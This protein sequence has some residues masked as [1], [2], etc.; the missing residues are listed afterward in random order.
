MCLTFSD[1]WNT[2][3]RGRWWRQY[4]VIVFDNYPPAGSPSEFDCKTPTIINFAK[5]RVFGDCC[6]MPAGGSTSCV[7]VF[8]LHTRVDYTYIANHSWYTVDTCEN[9]V[10][11]HSTHPRTK[12]RPL[13]I[14]EYRLYDSSLVL[15]LS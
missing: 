7:G 8:L 11:T 3:S 13:F 2:S 10:I 9:K 4:R 12:G 1:D 15:L 6:R 14:C 5:L